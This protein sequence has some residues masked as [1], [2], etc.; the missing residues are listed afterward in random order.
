MHHWGSSAASAVTS[1][2]PCQQLCRRRLEAARA[3]Q[4][5][6]A[7]AGWAVGSAR[8]RCRRVRGAGLRLIAFVLSGF[9][10]RRQIERKDRDHSKLHRLP[11]RGARLA[12]TR[13]RIQATMISVGMG[14]PGYTY[15]LPSSFFSPRRARP[16]AVAPH[17]RTSTRPGPRSRHRT[18]RR[19]RPPSRPATRTGTLADIPA[20]TA[21]SAHVI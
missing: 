1:L 14:G 16:R 8:A 18:M 10:L 12:W 2:A 5:A 20:E 11:S 6:S 21:F 15:M 9:I 7:T 3:G 17:R 4:P 19:R 13:T